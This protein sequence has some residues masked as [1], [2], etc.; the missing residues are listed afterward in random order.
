MATGRLGDVLHHLRK[1]GL[2]R[3]GTDLRD[4]ELLERFISRR[5]ETAFETLLRRHGPM[6]LGVCRR[7]LHNEADAEDAFQATFLVLV[8]R[9]ASIVPRGLVGN[10][11]YGV[12]H[13]IAVKA[14]AMS[15]KRRAKERAAP[16][17]AQTDAPPNGAAWQELEALLDEELARLP[18]HYRAALVLCDLENKPLKDAARQLEVPLGT[19]ASRLARAR[20]L[21]VSRLTARGVALSSAALATELSSGA[22]LAAVAPS[23]VGPTLKAAAAFA[24]GQTLAGVT[25]N[26]TALANAALA[27][28]TAARTKVVLTTVLLLG[29]ALAGV[30]GLVYR[31]WAAGQHPCQDI[32]PVAL[33]VDQSP[34][35]APPLAAGELTERKSRP[36][37]TAHVDA[38]GVSWAQADAGLQMG[39][40]VEPEGKPGYR[41]GESIALV[42]RARNLSDHAI[43]FWCPRGEHFS[44]IRVPIVENK[45]GNRREVS[46]GGPRESVQDIPWVKHTLASDQ[47]VTLH[48]CRF[49]IVADLDEKKTAR[50]VI[51]AEPGSY[52][53][54]YAN[55]NCFLDAPVWGTGAVAVEIVDSETTK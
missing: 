28:L 22:A 35:P 12:A 53:I 43:H 17:P 42:I 47:T 18:E 15:G 14:K 1:A 23:L 21:L 13:N 40:R 5:D 16:V 50:M 24:A 20:T 49:T 36:P 11:L 54:R 2:L 55:V 51:R 44:R 9:A 33:A 7:V 8:R 46:G 27:A 25:A 29:A 34:A 6:V 26:A 32:P 37:T 31:A 45:K 39:L 38:N 10:F 41:L 30:G 4:G 3:D 52:T 19:V 48:V